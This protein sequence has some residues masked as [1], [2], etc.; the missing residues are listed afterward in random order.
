MCPALI[1]AANR[2]DRVTGRTI[3]DEDSINTRN[4]FNQSGAPSGRR[5][6]IVAFGDFV[7]LEIII[8][9]HIGKPILRVNRR[10]EVILNVYGN[11]P[12]IFR[13][14]IVT[15]IDCMKCTAGFKLNM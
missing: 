15:K 3:I 4:G 14:I 2:N 1:F 6:A 12:I 9:I 7:N 8:I 10:W 11:N 5:W 13:I